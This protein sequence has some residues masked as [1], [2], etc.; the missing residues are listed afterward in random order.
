[1]RSR[2]PRLG[3]LCVLMLILISRA[4]KALTN[5]VRPFDWLNFAIEAGIAGLIVYEIWIQPALQ[6]RARRRTLARTFSMTI[7][8]ACSIPLADIAG[9]P[10]GVSIL[11][12]HT[13]NIKTFNFR[14]VSSASGGD[15][16]EGI[17]RIGHV[18]DSSQQTKRFARRWSDDKGG[19][20]GAWDKRV[21]LDAGETLRFSLAVEATA[22]WSGYL[23]F[24]AH[25][26]DGEKR[27]VRQPFAITA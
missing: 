20:S 4:W 5:G 13:T 16:S 21:S 6:R 23:S 3:L 1:M 7:D 22:P 15:V 25:D 19:I 14:F 2:A 11:I 9:F 12:G 8:G 27:F 24:S 10:V 17:V 18:G 26:A